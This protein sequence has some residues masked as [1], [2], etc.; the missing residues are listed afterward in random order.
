MPKWLAW[1]QQLQAVAYIGLTY[2]I[3]VSGPYQ[4]AGQMST[5][6]PAPQWY[7]RCLRTL[8]IPPAP[9]FA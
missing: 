6:P 8:T 2:A 4:G 5:T 9:S 3:E 1:V 7:G